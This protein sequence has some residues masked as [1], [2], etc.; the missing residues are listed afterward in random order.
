MTRS[1]NVLA[2]AHAVAY[3]VFVRETR[4]DPSTV[5]QV[6]RL[7]DDRKAD[8]LRETDRF[9]RRLGDVAVWHR[10]ADRL[11]HAFR[12]VLVLRDL[13]GDRARV[14]G[15]RGL[16][17]A[18]VA[19]ETELDERSGVE[20]P[21][22]GCRVVALP[23]RSPRS[24]V[25]VARARSRS[26]SSRRCASASNGV[27]PQCRAD[28]RDGVAHALQADVFFVVGDDDPPDA[29]VAG[30]DDASESDVAAG[31]VLQLERD[32]LED[33]R[34]VRALLE[35]FDESARARRV[36]TGDREA[37]VGVRGGGR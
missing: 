34:N 36:C 28:E 17:A 26:C 24:M 16:N 27:P 33:V 37:S 14:V 3:A 10:Q 4:R 12:V 11:E 8:L 18:K 22:A 25:R 21:N 5:A 7:E 20:T 2:R 32:V 19:T 15:E 29:G 13:D 23:P 9:V 35:P 6:Q 1:E 31:E 30:R